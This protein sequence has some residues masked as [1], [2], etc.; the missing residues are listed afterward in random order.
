MRMM[1]QQPIHIGQ[2]AFEVSGNPDDLFITILGSCVAVALYDP[3]R[4]VGGLNHF[5]LPGD[6][7]SKPNNLCYGIHSME[8]LINAMLK[9]GANRNNLKAKMFGGARMMDGFS[10]IGLKN[11]IFATEF[12][13]AEGIPCV[14][15]SIGGTQARK[16][17]FWPT[18]GD[19]KQMLVSNS[20]IAPPAPKPQTPDGDMT[21]F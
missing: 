3:A 19:V 7:E 16:L 13:Q 12:L 9:L 1:A 18:T 20:E 5:L 4:Q 17:R 21:F 11:A 14:G 10:D 6:T 15:Q 8:L 2:G